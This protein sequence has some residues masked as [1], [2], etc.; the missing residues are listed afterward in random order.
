M[1][2]SP[3]WELYRSFLAVIRDGSL[4]GAARSLSLTQPTIGRH[5]DALEQSLGVA[6]FTRSQHGLLPTSAALDLV[7]HAEDMAAA[8]EAL[9]RAASGEAGESH[10][11][12][13]LTASD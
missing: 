2:N 13:R 10:G 9:I 11:V 4:S 1:M 5:I 6:L 3:G 7:P 12:V 8:A